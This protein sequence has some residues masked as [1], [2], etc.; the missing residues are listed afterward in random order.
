MR[1]SSTIATGDRRPRVAWSA[2]SVRPRE[3]LTWPPAKRRDQPRVERVPPQPLPG[4]SER[5][6]DGQ[7]S[8]HR[9][10]RASRCAVP[11]RGSGVS[12]GCA[13]R[14]PRPDVMRRRRREPAAPMGPVHGARQRGAHHVDGALEAR[15]RYRDRCVGVRRCPWSP[16]QADSF[17]RPRRRRPFTIARPERVRIRDRKPCFLER[18]RL[19]GWKVRFTAKPLVGRWSGDTRQGEAPRPRGG[20][21]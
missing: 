16:G 19:F 17:A 21:W 20:S 4:R 3:E 2:A 10:R 18:R 14:P 12:R 1:P 13:P 15:S 11:L 7:R 8:R 5:R 6:H 9:P